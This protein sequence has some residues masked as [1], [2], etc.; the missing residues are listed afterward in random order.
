MTG[1]YYN[2]YFG[3]TVPPANK[4][5]T[6]ISDGSRAKITPR[7]RAELREEKIRSLPGGT[8]DASSYSERPAGMMS[9]YPVPRNSI[10]KFGKEVPTYDMHR[11]K[12]P[13]NWFLFPD[14]RFST[15]KYDVNWY[16]YNDFPRP[17]APSDYTGYPKFYLG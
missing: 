17:F 10:E 16:A 15:M 3:S 6:R 8:L 5:E 1:F 7:T 12:T 11:S 14:N 2:K 9:G 13:P 4:R